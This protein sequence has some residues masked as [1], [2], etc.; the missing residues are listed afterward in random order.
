M[1]AVQN[2]M[3]QFMAAAAAGE[4]PAVAL[5]ND[6]H[7]QHEQDEFMIGSFLLEGGAAGADIWGYNE[8]GDTWLEF[9]G[10]R[11]DGSWW[12][13]DCNVEESINTTLKTVCAVAEGAFVDYI[14]VMSVVYSKDMPDCT[15]TRSA[16]L[17]QCMDFPDQRLINLRDKEDWYDIHMVVSA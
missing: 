15:I 13:V 7:E 9:R 3:A 8:D 6:A 4:A 5:D 14:R 17:N 10:W 1:S 12:T 16:T 2:L 11:R